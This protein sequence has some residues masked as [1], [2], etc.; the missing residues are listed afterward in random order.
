MY[1]LGYICVC[2]LAE[3]PGSCCVGCSQFLW[4]NGNRRKVISSECEGKTLA[5]VL[6][7]PVALGNVLCSKCGFLKLRNR[8]W[9]QTRF[10]FYEYRKTAHSVVDRK[11]DKA[12]CSILPS[13]HVCI[14]FNYSS[15]K[16][17]S[18]TSQVF[19]TAEQPGRVELLLKRVISTHGYCFFF[20]CRQ[21]LIKTSRQLRKQ[22]FIKRKLFVPDGNR[23]CKTHAIKIFCTKTVW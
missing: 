3:L 13:S 2:L 11:L 19:N 4:K 21:I 14:E 5:S 8:T 7:K 12:H 18:Y 10:V 22:V 23:R 20:G 9:I 17:S 6:G 1:I 15:A 16:M